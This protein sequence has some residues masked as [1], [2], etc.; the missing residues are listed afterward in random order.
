MELKLI[1]VFAAALSFLAAGA[2]AAVIY[3][4]SVNGDLD[5]IGSA[6]VNL[7]AG[8]NEIFGRLPGTPPEDSDRIKFTQ[9]PNL[10]VDSIV[11]SFT[12]PFDP[13]T[14]GTAFNLSLFNNQANLFDDN[15]GTATS[16]ASISASFFDSSGSETGALVKNVFGTIWDFSIAGGPVYPH[17]DWK[18]TITTSSEN[19]GAVPLPATAPLIMAALG[20]LAMMRRRKKT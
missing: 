8:V 16:G 5:A 7:V 17:Q 3:D 13:Q 19:V 15:F 6:N 9:V 2:S 14:I 18:L 1:G 4:E 20:G 10:I 12:S 11:L